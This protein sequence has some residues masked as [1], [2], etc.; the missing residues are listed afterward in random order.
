M[1]YAELSGGLGNQMFIYAFARALGL[2]SGEDVTLLDRRDWQ[3]GAP[4]HTACALT[5]LS[6]PG[7]VRILDEPQFAKRHL[8]RQN[9]AKTLMIKTEQR[10]GMMARDWHGFEARMAPLL[11]LA[12]LHF[13]TDGYIPVR[14]GPSRDFLCWGYF[15]SARYFA[16]AE[17]TSV[18]EL[19]PA[20]PPAGALADA[21]RSARHSVCVHLRRGDYQAPE[22]AIFQVCTP[23]YY[24]AAVAAAARVWPDAGLFVFS[25][26]PAWA[27]A[28]LQTSGL[29]ATY[30]PR[31]DAAGDLALMQLCRGFVMSNSTYSWWAQYLA[32]APDKRVWAPDR[33]YAHTKHTDLYL[34][35]W[36]C[37]PTQ[38]G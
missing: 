35:A 13:A 9:L 34:P 21:I 37:I 4:A 3:S 2:R 38:P 17:Q 30:A 7:E 31:G 26:D 18:R 5:A 23:A 16:G 33:W 28:N 20:A 10:G 29:A 24:A 11:N 19:R 27:R 12:G 36:Q 14:R 32:P 1:I 15:Q 25:D 8:P 22:N 6:I